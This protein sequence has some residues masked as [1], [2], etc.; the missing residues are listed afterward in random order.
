MRK[1]SKLAAAGLTSAAAFLATVSHALA[2][3]TDYLYDTAFNTAYTVGSGL[4]VAFIVLYC[5]LA[6]VGLA[7]LVFTIIMIVDAAKRTDE[8][9]PNKVLWILVMLF[10]PLGTVVYFFAVKK[11]LDAGK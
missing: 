6:I 1:L 7:Y 10:V 3:S 4:S 5:C 2:Q 11:K 9:L 8:Q